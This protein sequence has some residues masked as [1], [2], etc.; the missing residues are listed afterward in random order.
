MAT[1]AS[2]RFENPDEVREF[3]DGKG[4]VELVELNGHVVGRSTYYPGWRW[5]EHVKPMTGS[6]SC[7][8]E[9]FG[10]VM[11]GRMALRMDDGAER[12]FGPGDI[13]HM[14][15]GHDAWII[16]DQQCVL[17]DFSGLKG[18]AQAA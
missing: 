11:E 9:H 4:R 10:Y 13:F 7:Q 3:T 15:A 14:P 12:E 6:D 5:S 1:L 2:K 16:G 18:Y 8:V 17:L